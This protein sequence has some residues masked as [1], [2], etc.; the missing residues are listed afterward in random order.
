MGR[1]PSRPDLIGRHRR[2]DE[3][4]RQLRLR[5]PGSLPRARF[6]IPNGGTFFQGRHVVT[7]GHTTNGYQRLDL[8]QTEIDDVAT[9][10]SDVSGGE[11]H[12]LINESGWYRCV[13]HAELRLLTADTHSAY[14]PTSAMLNS[15]IWVQFTYPGAGFEDEFANQIDVQ[16]QSWTDQ[17]HAWQ[18]GPSNPGVLDMVTTLNGVMYLE[19]GQKVWFGIGLGTNGSSADF[20]V[21]GGP[22]VADDNFSYSSADPFGMAYLDLALIG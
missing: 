17:G 21:S 3:Q 12:G 4:I 22:P 16:S 9:W 15:G 13:G 5:Q 11:P 10:D 6:S 1:N 2:H 20:I 19:A 7:G 14:F 8:S 18:A